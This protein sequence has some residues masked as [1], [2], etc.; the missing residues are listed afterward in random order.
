MSST[1]IALIALMVSIGSLIVSGISVAWNVVAF[2]ASGPKPVLTISSGSKMATKQ[3]PPNA[4]R[5][6]LGEII[7]YYLRIHNKGR[8]AIDLTDIVVFVT[9]KNNGGGVDIGVTPHCSP[10]DPHLPYRLEPASEGEW[11]LNFSD[12][13]RILDPIDR[14]IPFEVSVNFGNGTHQKITPSTFSHSQCIDGLDG[15]AEAKRKYG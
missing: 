12:L 7:Y 15:W 11:H 6:S 5:N 9:A 3:D 8:S 2:R 1:S 14:N 4:G 10:G 13:V